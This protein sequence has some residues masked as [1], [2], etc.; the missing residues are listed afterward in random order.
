MKPLLLALAL[1]A[2]IACSTKETNDSATTLDTN[3]KSFVHI[4]LFWLNQP[5][6]EEDRAAFEV[7][8]KKLLNDSEHIQSSHLGTPAGTPRSVVDNSWT[9]EIALYFDSPEQ[10]DLYQKEAAH[11]QF[12]E[13]AEHLWERVQVFDALVSDHFSK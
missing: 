5:D 13:E 8:I 4:V 10:Q 6:N 1:L 11:L 12:I 3:N 2:F 9:Y 7:A